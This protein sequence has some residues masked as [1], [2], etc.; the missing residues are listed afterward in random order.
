MS[1]QDLKHVIRLAPIIERVH[2]KNHPELTTVRE[3]VEKFAGADSARTTELFTQLRD[4]TDNY[5]VPDDGCEAFEE[6]YQALARADN[7]LSI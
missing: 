7:S 4:V 2:G 5:T 3:I 6:T 1:N